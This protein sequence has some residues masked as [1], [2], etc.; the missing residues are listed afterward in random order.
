VNVR[1]RFVLRLS[2][3][4]QLLAAAAAAVFALSCGGGGSTP[5]SSTIVAT[6]TPAATATPGTGTGASAYSCPIGMGDVDASCSRTSPQLTDAVEAAIDKLVRERPSLFNTTEEQGA[7]GSGQYR[8]LDAE[9]YLDGLVANL[10][11]AG[12][13]ADRAL[14]RERI[15][16]KSQNA[17]SEEWDVLTSQGFIRR[18]SYAYTQSCTPSSFPVAAEDL[19]SFVWVG[20]W[21]IECNA[22]T[23]APSLAEKILPTQCDGWITATPKLKNGRDVPAWVH[24]N[25]VTWHVREGASLVSVDDDHKF[26]NPFNKVLRPQGGVGIFSVCA[27]VLGKQGCLNSRTTN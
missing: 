3:P 18:T 6:P 25:E 19:V 27:T 17:F 16:V 7:A 23:V 1:R 21:A 20:Y 22:P 5:A 9:A 13:C 8:V 11:A 12:L 26:G 24:G 10:R 2:R 15:V 14:D 4:P